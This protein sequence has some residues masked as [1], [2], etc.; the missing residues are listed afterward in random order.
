MESHAVRQESYDVRA[1]ELT[2]M[3]LKFLIKK[4]KE[5]GGAD[6]SSDIEEETE[7]LYPSRFVSL[8]K[9]SWYPFNLR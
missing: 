5:I 4:N 2:F 8:G 9:N 7:P 3:R 6:D 1:E